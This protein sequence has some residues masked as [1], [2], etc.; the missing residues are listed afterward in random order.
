MKDNLSFKELMEMLFE[1]RN[2]N[3]KLWAIRDYIED[4][5]E[6]YSLEETFYICSCIIGATQLYKKPMV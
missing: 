4:R 5:K 2:D 3:I 6:N 1:Y